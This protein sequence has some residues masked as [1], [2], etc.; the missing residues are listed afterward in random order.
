VVK[1]CGRLAPTPSG[2]LH[3]G[4]GLAFIYT[5][6]LVRHAGGRLLLR[7][8]DLDGPRAK[9]EFV[10]AI[11]EDLAWLGLDYDLGPTGPDDFF[12]H[13]SQTHRLGLYHQALDH[14]ARLA[15]P[16]GAPLVYACARS[17][18][19]VQAAPGPAPQAQRQ[20]AAR[21]A[22]NPEVAWRLHT[23]PGTLVGL[24]PQWLSPQAPGPWL[25]L[26]LA[27]ALPDFV[28]RRRD[29]P[30]AYQLS[31]VVDDAHFGV[32]F[33]VRGQDLLASTAAQLH[34]AGWLPDSPLAGVQFYHHPL[35][36]DP[37]GQKLSKS[38]GATSLRQLRL[39]RP[40][41]AWLYQRLAQALQVPQP[42][43]VTSAAHLLPHFDPQ[44]WPSMVF[45]AFSDLT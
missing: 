33:V 30:P 10:T 27:Q 9:P 3:L 29:G 37:H 41:S 42:L 43:E 25:Q 45:G 35:V 28:V 1:L 32:N 21:T 11:F 34:L 38:A 7:I 44:V 5:W 4:N 18:A 40:G 36:A 23:P 22:P 17:R 19:Q 2:F 12:A 15:L 6:L 16:N 39:A 24:H 14:L 20:V 13:W 31:T 26:D 8:D